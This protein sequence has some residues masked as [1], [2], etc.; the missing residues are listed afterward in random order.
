M[1]HPPS[2]LIS[3]SIVSWH[4]VGQTARSGLVT[5]GS[6]GNTGIP[7]AISTDWSLRPYLHVLDR[8]FGIGSHLDEG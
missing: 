4:F 2:K 3:L 8:D 1:L 7:M 6:V 5:M